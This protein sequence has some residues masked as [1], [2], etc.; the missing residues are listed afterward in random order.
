VNVSICC[1]G[2][3]V[4]FEE[5]NNGIWNVYFGLAKLGRL[6]EEQMRLDNYA[7]IRKSGDLPLLLKRNVGQDRR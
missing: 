2:E 3:Y 6:I 1:A 7:G 4:G 5:I